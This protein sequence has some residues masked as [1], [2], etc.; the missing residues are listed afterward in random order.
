M[1]S[2]F[3]LILVTLLI[4]CVTDNTYIPPMTQP[5]STVEKVRGRLPLLRAG[6]SE[7]KVME[8][9]HDIPIGEEIVVSRTISDDKIVRYAVSPLEHLEMSFETDRRSP[10]S[11]RKLLIAELVRVTP[12]PVSTPPS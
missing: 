6:M 7:S 4:G 1:R 12:Q 10:R 8:L 2:L 11:G 3:P 9:L 5:P